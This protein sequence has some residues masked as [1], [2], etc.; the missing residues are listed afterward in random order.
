MKQVPNNVVSPIMEKFL[1]ALEVSDFKLVRKMFADQLEAATVA[2]DAL[3][4]HTSKR[5]HAL[6]EVKHSPLD[7]E[8][9]S[10]VMT[11]GGRLWKN[12]VTIR[13]PDGSIHRQSCGW[14]EFDKTG[15][16]I[17]QPIGHLA[18]RKLKIAKKTGDRKRDA[19]IKL[20]RPEGPWRRFI[21]TPMTH[22]LF[23]NGKVILTDGIHALFEYQTEDG[24]TRRAEVQLSSLTE[25]KVAI[26]AKPSKRVNKV[27]SS[28]TACKLTD[29]T[30]DLL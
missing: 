18:F 12:A 2:Q 10:Y 25:I 16:H 8:F 15:K 14:Q 23:K 20:S 26:P 24:V 1:A 21:E 3:E 4:V 6:S 27:K 5:K 11:S 22:P 19:W 7:D 17:G 29:L 13:R 28:E 9:P 30:L